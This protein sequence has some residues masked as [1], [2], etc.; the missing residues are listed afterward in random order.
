[1]NKNKTL[2][3][4]VMLLV[5]VVL[6]GIAFTSKAAETVYKDATV[7]SAS[8][9]PGETVTV[10]VKTT[11]DMTMIT[12][13]FILQY[14]NTKLKLAEEIE[15]VEI[16]GGLA[17]FAGDK[18][19]N[20]KHVGIV[21]GIMSATGKE[22]TV[23]AGTVLAT[24]KFQIQKN[25]SGNIPLTLNYDGNTLTKIAS[26]NVTVLVPAT[27]ITLD[28]TAGTLEKGETATLVATVAPANTTDK[29]V[30]T[31]SDEKVATVKDGKITAVGGGYATITA[32]A[33]NVTA[34]CQVVVPN[35]L[36]G[37][38]APETLT[39]KVGEK[40]PVE[41]E[42]IPANPTNVKEAIWETN[43]KDVVI[44]NEDDEIVGLKEGTATLTYK[45]TDMDGKVY[46]ASTKVTVVKADEVKQPDKNTNSV[47]HKMGDLDVIMYSVIGVA[48]LGAIATVAALKKRNLNK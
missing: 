39:I 38:K 26:A 28:Q 15:D 48:S 10:Q 13:G 33:G 8:G 7:T 14:D 27:S 25:V 17:A 18:V 6:C 36:T 35:P 30:W 45:V 43:N 40:K 24:I 47:G 41:L 19:E 37:I 44:V 31:S 20:G 23:P 22:K 42:P 29:V 21:I 46:T 32:K 1:M 16:P 2:K 12:E 4:V 11:K 9:K 34:T 3:A 5:M